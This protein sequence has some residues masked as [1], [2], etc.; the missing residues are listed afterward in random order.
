[1]PCLG[2]QPPLLPVSYWVVPQM[3]QPYYLRLEPMIL[4]KIAREAAIPG[5]SE[6]GIALGCTTKYPP[7]TAPI[8]LWPRSVVPKPW[9]PKISLRAFFGWNQ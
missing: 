2:P 8:D 1:M 5:R 4:L 3:P 6:Y 9:A 7:P